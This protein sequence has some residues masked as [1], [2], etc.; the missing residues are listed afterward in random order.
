MRAKAT[1]LRL[2]YVRFSIIYLSTNEGGSESDS[3]IALQYVSP[4]RQ[5]VKLVIQRF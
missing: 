2:M 1:K 5:S 3:D 4:V